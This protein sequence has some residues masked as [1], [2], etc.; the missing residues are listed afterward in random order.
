METAETVTKSAFAALLGVSPPC[1]T[2]WIRRG[3]LYGDA[4]VG[5][6]G[7]RKRIRVDIAREQLKQTLDPSQHL[8]ANGKARLDDDESAGI[9]MGLDGDIRRARLEQLELANERARLAR[10]VESGRFIRS[11]DVR[12]E[13]GKIAGRILTTFEGALGEFATAIAAKS[14]LSA[15]DALH[16]LRTTFRGIRERAAKIEA[17]IAKTLPVSVDDEEAA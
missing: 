10:E 6:P 1:V 12:Q 13:M 15:R 14:D 17:G 16:I 4:L 3:K 7:R 2:G 8:G 11:D 9:R 5:D